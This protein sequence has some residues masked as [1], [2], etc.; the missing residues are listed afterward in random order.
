M[1]FNFDWNYISAGAPYVTIST[2]SLG[3]NM[4]SI[5]LLGQ[6]EEVMIG[7]D[8][9]NMTIGIKAYDGNPDVKTYLFKSRLKNGWV[10]IGCK[11]FSRYLSAISNISFSPAKRYI[12]R[13]DTEEKVLYVTVNK[14]SME[15]EGGASCI[16]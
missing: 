5:N 10:R 4:P 6:P 8:E 11:E 12:A 13:F 15:E 2:T 14:D 1:K 7:F 3:F 16:L 9:T